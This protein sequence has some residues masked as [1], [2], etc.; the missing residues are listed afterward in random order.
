M[1]CTHLLLERERMAAT[2]NLRLTNS[3]P[4]M[5]LLLLVALFGAAAAPLAAQPTPETAIAP[6]TPT[7]TRPPT[8]EQVAEKLLG[9]PLLFIENVGQFDPRARFQVRGGQGALWLAEDALWITLLAPAP[10]PDEEMNL[11]E[12]DPRARMERTR[13]AVPRKGVNLRINFEGANP[14]PR[15]EPLAR[16]ETKISYFV[17]NDPEK[18]HR[19]VPVWGGVRYVD[20]YPGLDL[21]VTG[22]G[23]RWAWRMVAKEG[24]EA[25][26]ANVRLRVEGAEGL[27]LAEGAL[28]AETSFGAVALPLLEVV[29][30]DGLGLTRPPASLEGRLVRAPFAEEAAARAALAA[31]L[32]VDEQG[33]ALVYSGYLGGS[34]LQEAYGLA[35]DVAGRAYIVGWT[36][37]ADFPTTVG[38]FDTTLSEGDRHAVV[39]ALDAAGGA[40]IYSTYLGGSTWD[41]GWDVAVDEAGRAYVTGQTW[42]D[43]FPTTAGAVDTSYNG[44]LEAFVSVLNATGT[45]L[46]YSTYLGGSSDDSAH[47][48]AVDGAGRAYLTGHTWS[49]DFPCSATAFDTELGGWQDAFVSVLTAT[50][51]GFVYSTYLGGGD[52]DWGAAIAVDPAGRAY[53]TGH[54]WSADFPAT[55]SAWDASHNGLTDAWASALNVGGTALVYSTFL[56]GSGGD[57]AEGIAVDGAGQAYI[58]G[59]TRS[60][61]YPVTA[62]ALDASYNGGESDAFVSALN[63]AG[64]AA[65]YS[66]YLGGGGYEFAYGIAVDGAGRAYVTG[67]TSSADYPVTAGAY[68]RELSGGADAFASALGAGG[69]TPVYSTLLG[70]SGVDG[71]RGIAAYAGG[72][73]Y[74]AGQ[75]SSADY[76]VTPDAWDVSYNGG[77]GDMAVS[78]LA[79]P[80]AHMEV[81]Q[82]IQDA[83]NG[84]PLIAHKPALVR[85]YHGGV[86]GE[87]PPASL[88]VSLRGDGAGGEMVGSLL[89]QTVKPH[90]LSI[91]RARA[92]LTETA[93][94]VLPVEWLQGP[95]TLTAQLGAYATI[96]RTVVFDA[97]A[98]PSIT[99]V[100]VR[101]DG[102]AP[103]SRIE[104]AYRFAQRAWPVSRVDY[105]AWPTW[106][107]DPSSVCRSWGERCLQTD[108]KRR[109]NKLY[110]TQGVTPGYLFGWLAEGVPIGVL[111]SSDPAWY[112][113][114]DGRAGQGRVAF[115]VDHSVDGPV[116]L[117]HELGHDLGRF[118]TN[119][120][121]DPRGQCA[122]PDL[123]GGTPDRDPL[124]DWPYATAGIQQWG[125][126]SA[127]F[128]W[129]AGAPS[130]LKDPSIYYDYMSYCWIQSWG[131]RP[132]WTSP[133]TY[134]RLHEGALS[135]AARV[136]A[137][138]E[139][140]S[141][142]GIL[143]SG[144]VFAEG[145]AVLDPLLV[146]TTTQALDDPGGPGDY[147]LEA[148]DGAGQV[149]AGRCFS[150]AF[151]DYD[152]GAYT[153]I[154]AFTLAIPYPVGL[155]TV[156]LR[157]GAQ[158]LAEQLLSAHSPEVVVASPHD[159]D[160]LSARQ[161]LTIAWTGSDGDGDVL[162]Y[163][164]YYGADGRT[165]LPLASDIHETFVVVDP[166]ELPGSSVAMVRVVA[167][168]GLNTVAAESGTFTVGAKAPRVEL[169]APGEES[170]VSVHTPLLLEGRAYDLE[171]GALPDGA[172][173]W[174]SDLQGAL[175]SGAL[176]LATLERGA[177]TITLTATDSDGASSSASARIEVVDDQDH[178][179]HLPVVRRP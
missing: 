51:A 150:L 8:Q 71:G 121:D 176:V 35:V 48:I 67:G 6:T 86:C 106:N 60:T 28:Q 126:D 29:D 47:G 129:L 57:Y 117:A 123:W 173:N 56:G 90:N 168:D 170:Q 174:S 96:S 133:H 139:S 18:W 101:Y 53:V 40:L 4:A 138:A 93:N 118:H 69:A 39:S 175:G 115:G 144:L 17:G 19:D 14:A 20:I 32:T 33:D 61:D 59:W 88:S 13:G 154:D 132:A 81:T 157:K 54:T 25:A 151:T 16:S 31:R 27:H 36:R 44:G 179:L 78:V 10:Q 95:I 120:Y 153:G 135:G 137:R 55:P 147:C 49:A 12:G 79:I 167:S 142:Q 169:L 65:L 136:Q 64:T 162:S 155:S 23:G 7:A 73:M 83:A 166:G 5:A 1:G 9:A 119:G 165:W 103:S 72:R 178:F 113:Y 145:E 107:W 76:P 70:G 82:A 42:S 112:T 58:A 124:H 84:V 68:A 74:I 128:A 80:L 108:L 30:R 146:M 160:A 11:R 24:S 87:H 130:P 148:L 34:E 116:I 163:S 125:V 66:T 171:D 26:L 94:F 141:G 149:L 104:T 127:A 100:P 159:G 85:V 105:V 37:S 134:A 46:A 75:T 92:D 38:A 41:F 109:L 21:E 97:A 131:G 91:D 143:A 77:E 164:V 111:G 50:G 22:A 45:A 3:R 52:H 177:H 43:D 62:G 172:L 2:R 98:S 102:Q 152:T 15:L 63:A 110:A 99:Y 161:D 158:V 140:F 89:V 156:I 122:N 114:P